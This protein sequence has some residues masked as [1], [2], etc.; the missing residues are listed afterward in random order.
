M[1][2]IDYST[3]TVHNRKRQKKTTTRQK[4]LVVVVVVVV[5]LACFIVS[6]GCMCTDKRPLGYVIL[7]IYQNVFNSTKE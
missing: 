4:N 7:P 5:V 1:R 3:L 6:L 2:F